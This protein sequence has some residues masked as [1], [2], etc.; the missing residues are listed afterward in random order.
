[1]A[2]FLLRF[3]GIFFNLLLGN[4]VSFSRRCVLYCKDFFLLGP[5]QRQSFIGITPEA[6]F[7]FRFPHM[8][9]ANRWRRAA[10]HGPRFPS[11]PSFPSFSVSSLFPPPS[12]MDGHLSSWVVAHLSAQLLEIRTLFTQHAVPSPGIRYRVLVPRPM[13]RQANSIFHL[14][15]PGRPFIFWFVFW[16]LRS[17]PRAQVFTNDLLS[18]LLYFRPGLQVFPAAALVFLCFG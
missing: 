9:D 3:W 4:F 15:L 16:L 17:A 5:S 14:C 7:H 13:S 11:F 10:A 6:S 12:I 18:C 2:N 1:M 8:F